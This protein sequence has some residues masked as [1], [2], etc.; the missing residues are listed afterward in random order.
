MRISGRSG[1][2]GSGRGSFRN[3]NEGINTCFHVVPSFLNGIEVESGRERNNQIDLRAIADLRESL[4]LLTGRCC[5][6]LK[7]TMQSTS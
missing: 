5:C 6:S 1:S 7:G 3:S 2:A 4:A